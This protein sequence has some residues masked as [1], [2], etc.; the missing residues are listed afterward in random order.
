MAGLRKRSDGS[1]LACTHSSPCTERISPSAPSATS[2]R[3]RT[4]TGWNRVH[5]ASMAN[6]PVAVASSTISRVASGVTVNAFSTRIA[7]P[8]RSAASAIAR[9]WGWVVA[10]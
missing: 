6:V 2:S 10:M 9:C 8:A 3:S 5:M 4:T 1:G 7:L